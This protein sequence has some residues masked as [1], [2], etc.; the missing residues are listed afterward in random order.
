[1]YVYVLC[2]DIPDVKP[3][4][5]K[6]MLQSIY[7]DTADIKA[8]DLPDLIA[9]AKKFQLEGLRVLC[10]TFME[11]GV[12]VQNACTLFESAEKLLNEKQFALSF[13]EENAAEVIASPSFDALPKERVMTMLKAR[14]GSLAHWLTGSYPAPRAWN[15]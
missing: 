14:T 5:F 1:V 4:I 11:E 10:V 8:E 2:T 12:T 15:E 6:L 7:S 9:C 13:I 3:H